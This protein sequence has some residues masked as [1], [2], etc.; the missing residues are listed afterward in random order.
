MQPPISQEELRQMTNIRA[1]DKEAIEATVLEW[2]T[3]DRESVDSP[4]AKAMR[5]FLAGLFLEVV[6]DDTLEADIDKRAACFADG[7]QYATSQR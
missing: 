7:W 4:L 2:G 6:P 1:V 5:G 3:D